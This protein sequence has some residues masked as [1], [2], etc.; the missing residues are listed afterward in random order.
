MINFKNT[1]KS[2]SS[3]FL[4]KKWSKRLKERWKKLINR[5]KNSSSHCSTHIKTEIITPLQTLTLFASKFQRCALKTWLISIIKWMNYSLV[6]VNLQMKIYKL[7]KSSEN[8]LST[9]KMWQ[10]QSKILPRSSITSREKSHK[11]ATKQI[12]RTCWE[13]LL[14]K[15]TKLWTKIWKVMNLSKKS[16][17]CSL[18]ETKGLRDILINDSHDKNY[19]FIHHNRSFSCW[20]RALKEMLL[21]SAVGFTELKFPLFYLSFNLLSFRMLSCGGLTF[22]RF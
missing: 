20:L 15:L 11:R 9:M 21:F 8:L 5:S 1:K 16:K 2:S 3:Q 10:L 7:Q 12:L 18:S 19:K 22:N 13:K 4:R 14:I 17:L 6:K